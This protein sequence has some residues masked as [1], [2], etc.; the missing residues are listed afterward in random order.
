[1]TQPMEILQEHFSCVKEEL[2]RRERRRAELGQEFV[3]LENERTENENRIKE[4]IGEERAYEQTFQIIERG[5]WSLR[6]GY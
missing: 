3:K 4:L 5:E 1:V 6:R 2:A